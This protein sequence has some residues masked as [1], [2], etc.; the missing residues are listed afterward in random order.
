MAVTKDSV[1]SLYIAYYG[2]PAD[3][4]GL[5]YWTN[6]ANAEGL[7]AV[8]N[9]FGNSEEAT[10]LYGSLTIQARVNNLYQNMF[11]RNADTEGL[12]FYVGKVLDG[13]YTLAT[14]AQHILN[15]V[16][17]NV[18][19]SKADGDVLNKKLAAANAFT[20]A[21]DTTAEILKYDEA[22]EVTQGVAFLAG[23]T[24]AT[25]DAEITTK[26][27]TATAGL[28]GSD[29]VAKTFTLTTGEDT[30]TGT[31]GNDKFSASIVESNL[32]D[33]AATLQGFDSLDGGAGADTLKATL[34]D[35]VNVDSTSIET[36][37]LKGGDVAGLTVG[38]AADV[39]TLVNKMVGET[40][41]NG[42]AALATI[43]QNGDENLNVNGMKAT[44]VSLNVES[45]D[46]ITV[47]FAAAGTAKAAETLSVSFDG[48]LTVA[49]ALTKTLTVTAN[50]A[51]TFDTT[52]DAANDIFTLTDA[53]EVVTA[54]INGTG[55]IEVNLG[56]DTDKLT[57]FDASAL[58]GGVDVA[59]AGAATSVLAS[60]KGGQGDDDLSVTNL[61]DAGSI[62][63]GAG[64]DTLVTTTAKGAYTI[65]GGAGDDDITINNV[66][67]N[68]AAVINGGDGD[69][70][71][72]TIA[73]EAAYA[74]TGTTLTVNTGAGND[75]VIAGALQ[76]AVATVNFDGGAGDAD[77]IRITDGLDITSA[78][79]F[80]NFE[81]LDV[82]GAGAAEAYDLSR[83]LS[84]NAVL[85]NGAA[86]DAELNNV[87]AGTTL[88]VRDGGSATIAYNLEGYNPVTTVDGTGDADTVSVLLTQDDSANVVNAATATDLVNDLALTAEGIETV[89]INATAQVGTNTKG[90]VST[91]DDVAIAG[92]DYHNN[93]ELISTTV[94]TITV[95][96][97][98][99]VTLT[100]ADADAL[101]LIDASSNTGG[102]TVDFST[103]LTEITFLGGS[104]D[105][106]VTANNFVAVIDAGAGADSIT[107]GGMTTVV[108]GA[109]ADSKL[110]LDKDGVLD[111]TAMDSIDIDAESGVT[112]E[113]YDFELQTGDRIDLTAF[114]FTGGRIEAVEQ[115]G[116]IDLLA[117]VK[118]TANA[119]K[120][121]FLDATVDR[122]VVLASFE[123]NNYVFVDAN[124]D[125]NFAAADD[126]VI[127][128]GTAEL[129]V[130]D[131]M[132]Q[133]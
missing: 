12:N 25:T 13:T 95:S 120:D 36:Y 84:L 121:F 52:D 116:V 130:D 61:K 127:L 4:S 69:D 9:A 88:E 42:A 126:L 10:N 37:E 89:S 38:V 53:G 3:P 131:F 128:V 35:D 90:T 57:S 124:K 78:K 60:V 105:D 51:G 119:G 56:T 87:Q 44:S 99:Q 106:V 75:T 63:L 8:V 22:S 14:L 32:G 132:F 112:W 91:A 85:V 110:A 58:V 68:K 2:R 28:V 16:N 98:A 5:D 107:T 72:S 7:N 81:V 15:G 11:G 34:L 46:E 19:A 43:T 117:L 133:A 31:T 39:T 50:G 49:S 67:T 45:A 82:T 1:Q 6:R 111:F 80:S 41:I 17:P 101:T 66:V 71:I 65:D 55:D 40:T 20:L 21:L 94:E 100:V 97:N 23:I 27:G 123:N 125:G 70:T 18:P 109:A 103:N 24:A 26:V 96:G 108:Y 79:R 83:E 64:N 74:T 59:L 104:G 102:V 114:N 30:L 118:N 129:T 115:K 76:D 47:A 73:V 33:A 92:S 48:D 62:E 93:V 77:V 54:T 113:N 29:A 122:A 86:A